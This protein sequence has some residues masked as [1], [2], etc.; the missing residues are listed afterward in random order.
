MNPGRTFRFAALAGAA[1]LALLAQAATAQTAA[2]GQQ[3]AS[4]DVRAPDVAP[5]AAEGDGDVGADV[6]VTARRRS[7]RAQ[8][9]PIALSVVNEESLRARGDYTLGTIQQ[10]VPSLQVFSFNPRNTNVNI[11]GL[12]SNVAL[13]ND[14]LENGVGIYIDQVYY[15]RLGQSLF[16][17][18]DLD[19][20]EVLRG[21]QGTLFGKNTTAGA[22]NITSKAP[23][24]D[25]QGFGEATIGDYGFHQLRGSISGGLIDG[26]VAARLSVSDTHRD[27][28]IDDVTT[29]QKVHDFDNFSARGQLLITPAANLTARIIA[30]YGKQKQNCCIGVIA[31]AI[32]KYDNGA[33]IANNFIDRIGRAGY[34]PLPFTPFARVTD[35]DGHF[36][37]NM[38]T[39][40]ISG[41]VDWD[42]GPLTVTSVTAGRQ[43]NW[44]PAN[45][46][47]SIALPEM[48]KSQQQN[49]QR[50]FSQELRIASNGSHAIDYVAGAYYFYQVVR[51][52]GASAYGPAAANWL[53]PTQDPVV[54][55]AATNGFEADSKSN[56]TTHSYALF[57]Q[58]VWHIGDALSLTTGLR[59][60]H[61][62]KAGSFVQ[63]QVAG[64]SFAGLTPAQAATAQAIRN[65]LNPNVAY[66]AETK[67][68]SLSGLATLAWKPAQDVLVYATYGR[69]NKS[70]GLN[71]SNLPAGVTAV[72]APEKV[73]NYEIGVKSQLFERALT[74]NA[75][76]FWTDVANYQTAIT[77]QIVGTT[78]FRN[79]ITNI[80]LARS[81]GIEADAVWA[82]TSRVS[83]NL[84]GA[85]TDAY[86]V[87]YK[88]GPT[89]VEALNP[90]PAQPGG[91]ASTDLSGKPLA[92]VPK[93]AF[94]AGGDFTQPLGGSTE[95]Y[96]H[97]D[98][99]WRSSFYTAVS[100]SRYSLVPS[101]G[102]GN[103]RIGV[104]LDDGRYDLSVWAKNLFDKDYFQTLTIAATGLITANLGDP[105]TVGATFRVR[106]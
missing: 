64:L 22:I 66:S 106:I 97:A 40:G 23:S 83:L 37:A 61:E 21:P 59:F 34:T 53:F 80:P 17:L 105:R 82:V 7:E 47:D 74:L 96:G 99:S 75:A 32:T 88:Q 67:D 65:Q 15:G 39:W 5:G 72:V 38:D 69:G 92:G 104:R 100:D 98:Y 28:F 36:Q 51:G 49:N 27:G 89:P 71:L 102:V 46:A 19:R 8:D 9:V 73:D 4:N 45:D 41:Q 58:T 44:F 62:K 63:Q 87:D 48:L 2:A 76:A 84:S 101:Y 12:G 103:A 30:D 54:A 29:H 78:N 81:R 57:G 77:Q 14:G 79:Y 26:L 18:V 16:E 25:L 60:T 93:W 24:F 95:L 43:W 13:T 52:Y 50:Q 10:S 33:A 94:T 85:Y 68:D 3:L 42:V 70:G 55:N 86:Y 56:P 90:T 6:V 31:G 11:R 1:P 91:F 35:A 20:I